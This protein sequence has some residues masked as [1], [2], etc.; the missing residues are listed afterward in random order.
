MHL[1]QAYVALGGDPQNV[2]H[3][4]PDNP[5]TWP[6]VGVLQLIHGEEA[7]FNV[8]PVRTIA[9]TPREEKVRLTGIYGGVVENLY[10]GVGQGM[11]TLMPGVL[12]GDEDE[13]LA[14]AAPAPRTSRRAP[15]V[16]PPKDDG[17]EI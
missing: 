15:K 17:A 4:G 16:T 1:V 5:V 3:R 6:E 10:P 9:R 13:V 2:V 14:V 8:E 11:E 7:V 12:I